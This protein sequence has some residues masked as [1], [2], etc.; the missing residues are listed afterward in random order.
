MILIGKHSFVDVITNSSSELFVCDTDKSQEFIREFLERC[1]ETYNF[2]SGRECKFDDCFG[3]IEEITEESFEKFVEDYVIGWGLHR[4]DWKIQKVPDYWDFSKSMEAEGLKIDYRPAKDEAE[5]L[6]RREE[7][8]RVSD[9]IEAR[10]E[11]VK[12]E[13][14]E[15]NIEKLKEHLIGNI[16]IFSKDDNSIPYELFELIENT[17]NATRRHLG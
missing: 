16:C 10:W 13:W 5:E 8:K 7:N 11:R 17:L 14:K 12:T 4:W 3:S 15:K 2:G 6:K 9:E 1:L